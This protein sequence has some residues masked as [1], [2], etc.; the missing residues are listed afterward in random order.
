IK[1]DSSGNE[2]WNK[3]FGG[4]DDDGGFSVQQTSDGGYIITGHTISY[5]AGQSDVWLIKTDPFGIEQWNRTFGGANNDFGYSGQQTSDGGYIITGYTYSYGPG[6]YN[7]WLIKSD[8]FGIEEWNKTFGGDGGDRGYSTQQTSDYGYIIAGYTYSYGFFDSPVWLIKTDSSGN[9][10]WNKTF[11]GIDDDGGFSVQ[12]TSDYGYIITGFTM[13]YGSGDQ[14]VWLIKTDPSG[15]EQWNKTFGGINNDFGYS[16]QETSDGGYII[17]GW[18]RPYGASNEDVWLIKTD[19]LGNEQWNKTFGGISYDRGYSV[20]QTSDGGYIIT[21]YTRSYETSDED[22]LLIKTDSSGNWNPDGNLT[23]INLLSGQNASSIDFFNCTTT[24]PLSTSIKV[25]YSQD[26]LSWYNSTGALHGWNLLDNGF[27]S[28]DLSGLDWQGPNFYYRMNFISEDISSPIP[29]LENVNISY[30]QYFSSGTLTSQPFDS[31]TNTIWNTLSWTAIEPTG[32]AIKVQLRTANTQFNLSQKY[33]VGPDGTATTYYSSSPFDIW[34]DHCGDQWIQFKVYFYSENKEVTPVLHDVT[35]DYNCIPDTPCLIAPLDNTWTNNSKPTFNWTFNDLDGSQ[36][37]FQVLLSD[38]V[39]F[40][41]IVYDSGEQSSS[42]NYW[43]F[44][45]GTS[46]TTM[47]DGTWYWKVRVCDDDGCWSSYNSP[48]VVKID[49]KEPTNPSISINDD[50]DYMNSTSVILSLHAE[51]SG[52]GLYQMTFSNDG[53][54]WTDWEPYDN[55]KSYVLPSDDGIKTV[56]FKVKDEV[57]NIGPIVSDSI[58]YDCTPPTITS[59]TLSDP[60]PTKSG[61]VTFTITFSENMSTEISPIVTFGKT[62]PYNTHT[63]TQF[64]YSEDTW[65]GTFQIDTAT[66]D[67]TNTISVSNAQDLAGNQMTLNVSD[68]FIIDAVPPTVTDTPTGTNID[69]TGAITITFSEPMNHSSVEN[70]ISILPAIPISNYDW[71]GNSLTLTFS[72]D[73]SYDTNYNII[74]DTRAEDPAGN[75]LGELYSYQFTTEAEPEEDFPLLWLIILLVIIIIV[76]LFLVWILMGRKPKELE[77]EVEKEE[78][79]LEES[80][81]IPPGKAKITEL[82]EEQE[83]PEEEKLPHAPGKATIEELSEEEIEEKQDEEESPPTKKTKRPEEPLEE[84]IDRLPLP[85]PDEEY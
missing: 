72:S 63:I 81:P 65:T 10:Q 51:D 28:I 58:I 52:S 55:S 20:K 29:I 37:G 34:S 78:D 71:D 59:I 22:V 66:G 4:I 9:E 49:T 79:E 50:D 69:V 16:V 62:S 32:T 5:S 13:S 76:A 74:I 42:N 39:G 18:T 7:V 12:Q 26:G 1:T 43:Q 67:G 17:T 14:D 15:V 40:T 53:V 23:S 44:P 82:L 31:G 41:D 2:Q 19:N 54:I 64:L 85:A 27:I 60:S 35:I 83:Q 36:E 84:E 80:P 70:A 3:T 61:T 38:D 75:S 56:Y 45:T 47:A 25:Q 68:T 21:G 6:G 57:G 77:E 8:P 30:T 46:Y 24:I 33:F 48:S 11:G 73:L